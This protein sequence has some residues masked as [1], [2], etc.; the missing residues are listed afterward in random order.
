MLK[1]IGIFFIG[2]TILFAGG[3][4]CGF[5]LFSSRASTIV[6]AEVILT[7]L[8]SEGFLIT[9]SYVFSQSIEINKGTGSDWKDIFWKQKITA[10]GNMKVSS[11]IDLTTL[12]TSSL[13][14][15]EEIVITLPAVTT[16]SAELLGP[17]VLHNEQGILK[18]LLNSEDGYNE[19][20]AQIKEEA[21][22]AAAAP[23]LRQEAEENAKIQVERLVRY[24]YP[25]KK[26]TVQIKT[27]A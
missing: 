23:E 25:S 7:N 19:A 8:K 24:L 27:A 12:S 2:F 26:I 6:N 11:G 20:T 18:R 13:S 17:V 9:Q 14:V 21:L 10:S 4:Y 5:R 3:I 16:H 22:K 1:K 15:G